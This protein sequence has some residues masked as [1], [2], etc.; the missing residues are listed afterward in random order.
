MDGRS[1][2]ERPEEQSGLTREESEE[3]RRRAQEETQPNPN[4]G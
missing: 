3:I 4:G 1:R 2:E